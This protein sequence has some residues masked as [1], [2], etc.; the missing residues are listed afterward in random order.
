MAPVIQVVSTGSVLPAG[1]FDATVATSAHALRVGSGPVPER[2]KPFFAVGRRTAEAASAAGFTDVCRCG[3]DAA[4]LAAL[5][6]SR[7]SR[8]ACLLYLAGRDRKPTLETAL[9]E[10]GFRLTVHEVYEARAVEAW[11]AG[12][13]E[14]LRTDRVD[15][16]LH[17][18][19]RSTT[20]SLDLARVHQVLP[21]FLRLRHYCL[22][23]DV[24][25][26]LRSAGA[27]RLE[28]AS[29]PDAPSLLALLGETAQA[30]P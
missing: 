19:R 14:R 8:P 24:A 29:R 26:P 21:V 6:I 12:V 1:S 22:S 5:V 15:A 23:A 25:A 3:S 16:A 30:L 13:L 28:V 10:A 9:R 27:A 20:L 7:L 2:R 17:F 4:E 11:P 18:S